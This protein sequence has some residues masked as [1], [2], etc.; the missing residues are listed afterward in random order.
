MKVPLVTV[1]LPEV[2]GSAGVAIKLN[3]PET[4]LVLASKREIFTRHWPML[5]F[6][7]C[8]LPENETEVKV[9]VAS[10]GPV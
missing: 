5:V 2:F 9:A 8:I 3:V 10:A 7:F 1:L 4:C 6:Q